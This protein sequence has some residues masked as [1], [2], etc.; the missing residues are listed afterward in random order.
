MAAQS[1]LVSGASRPAGEKRPLIR[2]GSMLYDG[3]VVAV[4]AGLTNEIIA[5]A[6]ARAFDIG[7]GFERLA[8]GNAGPATALAALTA[9]VALLVLD[10]ATP[11][12]DRV[13]AAS[14]TALFMASFIPVGALAQGAASPAAI[15]TLVVMHLVAFLM[16]APWLLRA[17]RKSRR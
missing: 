2:M 16:I 12:A 11:Q 15:V 4:F 6:A 7:P 8:F 13:F 5:R 10:R 17:A 3:V 9:T 1:T 14:A